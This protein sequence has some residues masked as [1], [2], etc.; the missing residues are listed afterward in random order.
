MD[1]VFTSCANKLI[2]VILVASLERNSLCEHQILRNLLTIS[3]CFFYGVDLRDPIQLSFTFLTNFR[4]QILADSGDL[5]QS[6]DR[7]NP[8]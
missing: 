5:Q 3:A 7:F 4:Y 8:T 2:I 6:V 1:L